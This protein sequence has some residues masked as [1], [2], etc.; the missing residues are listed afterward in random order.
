MPFNKCKHCGGACT[1]FDRE[2]PACGK[3]PHP[4]WPIFAVFFTFCFLAWQGCALLLDSAVKAEPKPPVAFT[5]EPDEIEARRVVI[6]TLIDEQII[7]K[8]RVD[9]D[10]QVA[11]VYTLPAF[12]LL[13]VDQKSSVIRVVY[14]HAFELPESATE[15]DALL[16]QM[17]GR[18][19]EQLRTFDLSL[20]GLRFN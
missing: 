15:C 11:E 12:D 18:T 1:R 3:D 7:L 8:T 20:R 14:F 16:Y 6:R 13:N 17:D 5:A 10:D 19:G 2:C 9:R 4:T